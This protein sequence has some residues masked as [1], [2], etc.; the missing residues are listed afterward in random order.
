MKKGVKKRTLKKKIQE[1]IRKIRSLA[2]KTSSRKVS[3]KRAISRK[4]TSLRRK[5]STAKRR[6]P[7]KK[8]ILPSTLS[9]KQKREEEEKVEISKFTAVQTPQPMPRYTL[10][11]RYNDNRLV[12]IPRDPWWIHAYW[13]ISEEKIKEVISAI[14]VYEKEGIIWNLRVHDVSDIRDFNG[15]NSHFF[16]D[17]KINFDAGNWYI[18]VNAP[19]REWCVEIGFKTKKDNFFVV[20]RS[21]IIKTPYFGISD[22]VDEEWVLPE[23]EY[24]KVLGVYDLGKSSLERRRKLEEIL[25]QQIS[26]GFFSGSLSSISSLREKKKARKFFLEIWTELILSGKTTPH[27]TVSICGKKINLRDDGTFSI[28]Y[29]L[30]EGDFRFDVS[31]TSSDRKETIN[32]VPAVKRYTIK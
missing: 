14:P 25:R 12:L 18:N 15:H 10:P 28:R 6:F 24:F 13:D 16:F 1:G 30:G 9:F 23:D 27:A 22:V 26:S 5:S 2:K 29:A 17:L 19:Q 11:S 31:A 4:R 20:L 3:S 21:N 32:I 8:E 7:S